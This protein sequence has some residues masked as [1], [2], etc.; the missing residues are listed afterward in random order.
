MLMFNL[1]CKRDKRQKEIK[2]P[3]VKLKIKLNEIKMVTPGVKFKT[4]LKW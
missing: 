1:N 3:D 4:R 2:T